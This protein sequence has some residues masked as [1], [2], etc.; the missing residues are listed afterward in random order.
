MHLKHKQL[1]AALTTLE[2]L[3][4]TGEQNAR[5]L[6]LLARLHRQTGDWQKLQALEPRLR[7]TRGISA[8]LADD[9][10]AQIYL[11]RLKAAGAKR[12]LGALRAAW[13]ETPKSLAQ[14]P[15]IVVAYARAA[16]ACDDH[17]AA[18]SGSARQHR[19][20]TGTKR[21]YLRMASSRPTIRS[22]RS[23]APKAGCP[24][25]RKMRHCC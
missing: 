19:R 21:A 23:N 8:A 17:D 11:D 10:V 15:D 25:I 20:G 22:G 6:L 16:M 4:A 2:Q 12:R 1:Q 14:R 7:S 5:G 3:E 18:E 13:K 9:T 24:S